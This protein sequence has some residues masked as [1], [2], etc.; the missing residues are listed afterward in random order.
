MKELEKGMVAEDGGS[1][2]RGAGRWGMR[3]WRM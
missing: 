2:G 3:G 1:G